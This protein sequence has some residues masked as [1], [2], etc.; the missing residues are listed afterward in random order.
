MVGPL[1]LAL[2]LASFREIMVSLRLAHPLGL[3]PNR[4]FCSLLF[5]QQYLV[6]PQKEEEE[7]KRRR[8]SRSNLASVGRLLVIIWTDRQGFEV[9]WR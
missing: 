3:Q 9:F 7:R 2:L 8:R 1:G 5:L 4:L 6:L